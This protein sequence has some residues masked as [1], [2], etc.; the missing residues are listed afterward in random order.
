MSNRFGQGRQ[1]TSTNNNNNKGFNKS[2]KK[3]LPKNPNPKPTLSASLR[4]SGSG[5]GSGS[6]SGNPSG[7]DGGNGNFVK[8]LPQDEAVAAGLGAEDGG[9][10]PI[11]SQRVVDL[12]NSELSRL[13][14]LKPKEFWKQGL[15]SNSLYHI[16][17]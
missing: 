6:S 17:V 3:F 5:S 10:D 11:E 4:E 9:L 7:S 12:L 13:L 16:H 14:K 1:D 15:H 8:Y 2:H